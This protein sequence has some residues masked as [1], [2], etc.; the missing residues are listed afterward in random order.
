MASHLIVQTAASV[1]SYSEGLCL[2]A[3]STGFS[4]LVLHTSTATYQRIQEDALTSSLRTLFGAILIAQFIIL[5][6]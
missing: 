1:G 5:N 2:L 3:F 4:A 6:F